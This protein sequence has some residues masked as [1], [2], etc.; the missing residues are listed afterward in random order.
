MTKRSGAPRERAP[1]GVPKDYVEA[2]FG[3][4]P[5]S[6]QFS[7][8]GGNLTPARIT[9]VIARADMGYPAG[10]VDLFHEGRQKDGHTH[11]VMQSREV[12]ISSLPWDITPPVENPRKKDLKAAALCKAALKNCDS[13]ASAI[14]HFEGSGA[15]FGHATVEVIWR[16]DETGATAGLMVPDELKIVPTRR[17][18]FR[19]IDGALLFDPT[20]NQNFQGDGIDLI[21]EYPLGKFLQY[22]PRVNGDVLVREGLARVTCWMVAFRTF[23]LSDWLKLA[24]IGW[25]PKR[26]GKYPKDASKPDRQNLLNILERLNSSGVGIHPDTTS[27]ELLWP[28]TQ[29]QMSTHRELAEYLARELSK[30]WLGASDVVEPGEIGAKSSTV[31]RD[32]L[33]RDIRDAGAMGI[34]KLLRKTLIRA[35]YRLN[36]G[37]SIEPASA[38]PV[39]EDPLDLLK[40]SGSVLNLR[41]AG[42]RIPE[43]WVQEQ[44][45][46]PSPKEGEQLVGDGQQVTPDKPKVEPGSDS[47][48]AGDNQAAA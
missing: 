11:S 29:R 28:Q 19:E 20:G 17:F 35:F 9:S 25:K 3:E 13:L 7:R 10:L 47:G 6:L 46:I 18:G 15:G 4:L 34:W 30:A 44:T 33:R 16:K 45:G 8:I 43:R 42:F 1:S 12:A 14:E 2:L 22:R 41:K 40:F 24:E 37:D 36:Y 31:V 39:L 48:G 38:F 23:D 5:L 32:Q 27:I 26:V 21:A